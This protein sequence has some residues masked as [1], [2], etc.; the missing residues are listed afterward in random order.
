MDPDRPDLRVMGKSTGKS[1]NERPPVQKRCCPK[2]GTVPKAAAENA[3]ISTKTPN[4]FIAKHAAES[5]ESVHPAI[6]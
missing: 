3:A 6:S 2:T 5:S 4:E 1:D